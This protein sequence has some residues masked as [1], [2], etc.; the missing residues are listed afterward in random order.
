MA[1]VCANPTSLEMNVSGM[2]IGM[3]EVILEQ[4]LEEHIHAQSSHF[5]TEFFHW[6][7]EH[8]SWCHCAIS[9]RPICLSKDGLQRYTILQ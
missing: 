2:K 7:I 9:V 6:N 5:L 1:G 8:C 4:H 3:D